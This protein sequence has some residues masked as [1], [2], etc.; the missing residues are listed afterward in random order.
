VASSAVKGIGFDATCSLAVVDVDGNPLSI[1][2]TGKNVS[3]YYVLPS[4][5]VPAFLY[6]ASLH[7]Y[8]ILIPQ[9]L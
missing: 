5:G 2:P 9:H 8:Y 3:W 7:L 6:K 4:V 1:S